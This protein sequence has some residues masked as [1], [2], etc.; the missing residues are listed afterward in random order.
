MK[1]KNFDKKLILNKKT[2]V[3]LE[4]EQMNELH[5]GTLPTEMTCPTEIKCI[6]TYWDC[7]TRLGCPTETPYC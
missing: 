7:P 3:T 4:Q 1:T 6:P 2:I 5:G